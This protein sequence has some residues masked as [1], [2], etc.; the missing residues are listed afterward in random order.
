M[1][2]L[3]LIA[4]ACSLLP[5]CKPKEDELTL[6]PVSGKVTIG[7]TPMPLG[8]VNFFPDSSKGNTSTK[9]PSAL[10]L[11]DGSFKLMTSDSAG[12][13]KEGAPPGWYKVVVMRVNPGTPE[14]QK[15]KVE[16]YSGDYQSEKKTKLSIEVKEGAG[17]NAYDIKLPKQ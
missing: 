1:L 17:A 13:R 4:V 8:N 10:V 5:A 2:S 16:S 3:G 6:L 12:T 9:V 7:G 11:E 14:Q 15:L